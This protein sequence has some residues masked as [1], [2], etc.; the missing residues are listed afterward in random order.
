MKTF[1][2]RCYHGG[3]AYATSLKALDYEQAKAFCRLRGWKLEEIA[4]RYN[5]D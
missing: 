5:P 1:P 2:A 4:A 3:K